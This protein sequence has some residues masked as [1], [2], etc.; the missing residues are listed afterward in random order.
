MGTFLDNNGARVCHDGFVIANECVS[1]S[2]LQPAGLLLQPRDGLHPRH[3]LRSVHVSARPVAPRDEVSALRPEQAAQLRVIDQLELGQVGGQS[4]LDRGRR[5]LQQQN[6]ARRR[7]RVGVVGG[8]VQHARRERRHLPGGREQRLLGELSQQLLH[9]L[10]ELAQAAADAWKPRSHRPVVR[11]APQLSDAPVRAGVQDHRRLALDHVRQKQPQSHLHP[12]RRARPIVAAELLIRVVRH[13]RLGLPRR[14]WVRGE[15]GAAEEADALRPQQ[16]LRDPLE[17][18]ML[19]NLEQRGGHDAAV[20]GAEADASAGVH[21]A[22]R[23]HVQGGAS[24]LRRELRDGAGRCGQLRRGE[25]TL[26]EH[27]HASRIEFLQLRRGQ[28]RRA[29]AVPTGCSCG[30]AT[31]G[32][33]QT[34]HPDEA[35]LPLPVRVPSVRVHKPHGLRNLRLRTDVLRRPTAIIHGRIA[36]S[37]EQAAQPAFETAAGLARK[38]IKQLVDQATVDQRLFNVNI[39]TA[40]LAQAATIR[41]VP[42]SPSRYGDQFIKRQ[43]PKGRDYFW[44]TTDPPPQDADQETDLLALQQGCVTVTPLQ[45]NMTDH[46]ALTAA[47][48]WN[49]TVDNGPQ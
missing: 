22:V 49:L 30:W 27:E 20:A 5:E 12:P 2:N 35:P 11:A 40:A 48:N 23:A 13:G 38:I 26:V 42:M 32:V 45:Y 29:A 41:V 4:D 1:P 28:Q 7:V 24:R 37:L 8:G 16:P 3:E 34:S 19:R 44:A 39:P 36:V 33:A 31:A 10:P 18:L 25:R 17:P 21:A 46:K 6:A 43:D 47:E 9:P 15:R 14:V